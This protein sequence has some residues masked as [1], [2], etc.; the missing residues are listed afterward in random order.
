MTLFLLLLRPTDL[1]E[2][3]AGRAMLIFQSEGNLFLIIVICS[4]L[5][6]CGQDAI[7]LGVMSRV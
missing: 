6:D 5:N 4:E 1:V 3:D 7:K 2:A